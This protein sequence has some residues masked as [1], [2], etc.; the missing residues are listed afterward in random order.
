MHFHV[1]NYSNGMKCLQMILSKEN[2]DLLYFVWVSTILAACFSV[3]RMQ[4]I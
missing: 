1:H 4:L 3:L 2:L